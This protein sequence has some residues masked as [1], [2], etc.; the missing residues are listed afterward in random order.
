MKATGEAGKAEQSSRHKCACPRDQGNIDSPLEADRRP[1]SSD[2]PSTDRCRAFGSP[3]RPTG[4]GTRSPRCRRRVGALRV[5]AIAHS[6]H[7]GWPTAA[8]GLARRRWRGEEHRVDGPW[9]QS[10][11]RRHLARD[12]GKR[13]QCKLHR[14]SSRSRP[15][16]LRVSRTHSYRMTGTTPS[17]RAR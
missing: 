7:R 2:R 14:T 8:A 1:M 13:C 16:G 12:T 5:A 4:A 9:R 15:A 11:G 3:P 10:S 17:P 6:G